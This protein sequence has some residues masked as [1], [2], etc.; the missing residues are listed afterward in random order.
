MAQA[1]C[2][3]FTP[4]EENRQVCGNCRQLKCPARIDTD[5]EAELCRVFRGA[6]VKAFPAVAASLPK[7]LI[8][9]GKGGADYQCNNAMA[10]CKQLSSLKPPVKSSPGQVAESIVAAVPR[11]GIVATAEATKVGF[12]NVNV[13]MGYVQKAVQTLVK[14]GVQPPT[15]EKSRILVDFSSPNIAKKMHVGHLRSTI[16]GD[17]ICRLMEFC[18]HD[19]LRVNHVGDWGTQFGMLITHL[20][21]IC[22]DFLTSPPDVSDLAAFYKEAKTRFDDDADFK[23]KSHEEVVKLQSGDETNLA[24]WKL[25]CDISRREFSGIYG[26]LDV[27]AEEM[28]ESF[29]NPIIPAVL[30]RLDDLSLTK[31]QDGMKLIVSVDWKDLADKKTTVADYEKC[32]SVNLVSAKGKEDKINPVLLQ[33]ARE[34]DLARNSDD[35][36]LEIASG[37]GKWKALAKAGPEDF[38]K[39]TKA[40]AAATFKPKMNAAVAAELERLGALKGGKISVPEFPIPLIVTKSDGG[41]SYDTTDMAAVY[42]RTQVMKAK[43]IIC[44]TD[45]GQQSHFHMV[46]RAARDAGWSVHPDDKS[47]IRMDHVGFGVVCGNDKK[48]YRTRSGET[49]SLA[50]LLEEG[51]S[52]AYEVALA[53]QTEKKERFAK[54]AEEGELRDDFTPFTEAELKHIGDT[55]GIGAIKYCDLRQN[56]LSDYVFDK[57][58]M[59]SLTG[60]TVMC[61]LYSYARCQSLA[62]KAGITD[63]ATIKDTPIQLELQSEKYLALYLLKFSQV[64]VDAVCHRNAYILFVSFTCSSFFPE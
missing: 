8:T 62:R 10:L 37:K 51:C 35:G 23:K 31:M 12:I 48:R 56:R 52:Q 42:H 60:N 49:A 21:A 25:I 24:A 47:E 11:D 33:A 63:V 38:D 44:V 64:V 5:M 39:F 45:L 54:L 16:I 57:E 59:C 61:M 19:V 20:K 43:R 30:K 34:A 17:T 50:D 29:Y 53:R 3:E 2:T 58:K 32:L 36:E 26:K 6:I 41:F 4:W 28:G 1:V 22:P 46:F 55:V 7:M 15:V 13:G 18:G 27:H 40:A 9:K 14:Q